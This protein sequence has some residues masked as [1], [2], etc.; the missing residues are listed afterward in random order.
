MHQGCL[1]DDFQRWIFCCSTSKSFFNSCATFVNDT[2]R[3]V[4]FTDTCS[5]HWVCLNVQTARVA[6]YLWQIARVLWIDLAAN[7]GWINIYSISNSPSNCET[8]YRA[9]KSVS[10][11]NNPFAFD[12]DNGTWELAPEIASSMIRSFRIFDK[13]WILVWIDHHNAMFLI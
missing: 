7:S 4:D 2:K 13:I 8:R 3:L 5:L 1:S 10:F 12:C 6:K 11:L 9:C